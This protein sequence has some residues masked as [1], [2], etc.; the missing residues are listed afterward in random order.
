MREIKFRAWDKINKEMVKRELWLR[1]DGMELTAI[2]LDKKDFGLFDYRDQVELIQF[3]GLHDKNGKE[4]Y[5]GDI[6]KYHDDFYSDPADIGGRRHI[7]RD[8]LYIVWWHPLKAAFWL[9][10]IPGAITESIWSLDCEIIG[11]IYENPELLK[12]V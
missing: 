3:T 10:S 4:I 9:K 11:N 7:I 1:L 8:R 2:D 12:G 6:V 5:E